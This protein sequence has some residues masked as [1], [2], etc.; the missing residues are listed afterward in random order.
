MRQWVFILLVLL[1]GY[2]HAGDYV[3]VDGDIVFQTSRSRQSVAILMATGSSYS[4]MGLVLLHMGAPYVFEAEQTV[5]YTP[6]AIWLNR[7]VGGHYVIKR[8]KM[9]L[10]PEVMS[11]LQ[12][13]AD[14]YK[15]KPYDLTFEWSDE[16]IYCSE[17]VWKMY[18]QATGIEL[19]PL[20]TLDSFDLRS[21][22]VQKKMQ[23]R[24]GSHVPLKEPVISPADIFKSTLLVSVAIR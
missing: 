22:I 24:Y 8:L 4:H 1:A 12:H 11:R 17:L 18:R 19:A 7:G 6:L 21:P 13:Y 2:S 15:G 23:E 20:R 14:Q 16:K 9:P 5:R 10:R 3:P